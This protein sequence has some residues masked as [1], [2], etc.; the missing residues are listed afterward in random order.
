MKEEQEFT[1][2]RTFSMGGEA[3][4]YKSLLDSAGIDSFIKNDA[5]TVGLPMLNENA[6]IQLV[7]RTADLKKAQEFLH[8]EIM[9]NGR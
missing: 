4:I 9:K 1:V 8:A 2:L 6:G 7:V 5:T 3:A